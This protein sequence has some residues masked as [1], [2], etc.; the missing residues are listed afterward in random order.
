M[1]KDYSIFLGEI[2][3]Q[4]LQSRYKA[5]AF[6]NR[7]LIL[8]YFQI[9]TRLSQKIR[10]SKWGS[11]VVLQL[12]SDL[13]LELKGLRGFSYRNLM[14]MRVFSDEYSFL[15]LSTADVE[16][17]PIG[18]FVTTPI[19]PGEKEGER[20]NLFLQSVTAEFESLD[21]FLKNAFF[22]I[23]FTQHLLLLNKCKE[24]KE[25]LFYMQKTISHQWTVSILEHQLASG[26]YHNRGGLQNNF[27]NALPPALQKHAVDAFKGEY[28]LD[29]IRLEEEDD[30]RVLENRI[31]QNIK[32]FILSIG[33]DFAFMG[34]Q[35]RLK[36]DDEEFFID[37]LFFHR[38]L[39]C[40]VAI[41]LKHGKFKAE[42]AG[43]M[44]LYLSALDE[45]VKQEHENPSI[46]IVLCKSKNS[47]VVEFAFRDLNKAMGV[48]T[49]K[50]SRELPSGY[51]GILP[52]SE[53][54]K[55]VLDDDKP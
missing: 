17:K 41:E 52:N 48:A 10:D 21:L 2:K 7:E 22:N 5:A 28:L 6:V 38:K 24:A 51:Q 49:F 35:Y 44:N 15:Q 53:Q 43:K 29:F 33:H 16:N 39:Q 9:G 12:A 36:I 27:N 13:Q 19:Q 1:E 26:L 14:N 32:K 20:N 47:K 25:R 3:T 8:L 46:G 42:Y 23:S 4:I 30:E 37:L 55:K 31:V 18:Y 11:K 45:Y 40:L 54:L 34:N 50:T